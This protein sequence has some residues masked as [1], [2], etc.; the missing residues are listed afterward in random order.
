YQQLLC[1]PEGKHYRKLGKVGW[2]MM[3]LLVKSDKDGKLKTS[4]AKIAEET[5]L[6]ELTVRA[7][8]RH[9]ERSKYI[10]TEGKWQAIEIK[11]ADWKSTSNAQEIARNGKSAVNISKTNAIDKSDNRIRSDKDDKS[12]E[13]INVYKKNDIDRGIPKKLTPEYIAEAFDDEDNIAFYV[14]AFEN[15]G[16]RIIRKA[17]ERVQ[18]LPSSKIKKSRGALFNY[19]LKKYEQNKK[20]K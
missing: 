20:N 3:Y 19:L 17:F 8:L 15:Y 12:D 7:W 16:K 11:I 14:F 2:L 6:Y 9:L 4:S 5:G 10:A 18:Y 13:L 1:N